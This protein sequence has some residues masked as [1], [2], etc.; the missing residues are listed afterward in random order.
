M[1]SMLAAAT[2]PVA[3]LSGSPH[4]RRGRPSEAGLQL[5]EDVGP[6]RAQP[7]VLVLVNGGPL[8]VRA[9]QEDPNVGAIVEAFMPG[10]HGGTAIAETIFGVNNPGGKLPVTIY[11]SSI[12]NET[13]FI[14]M[15]MTNGVGRSYKYYTGEPSER[16][17]N[18]A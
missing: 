9:L 13:D 6:V 2:G 17:S 14:S 10:V 7:V 5:L 4:P 18:S 15:D 1:G 8:A 11:P 12:I 16:V 3:G